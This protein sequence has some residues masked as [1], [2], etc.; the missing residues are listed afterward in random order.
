MIEAD[1]RALARGCQK[2]A[3]IVAKKLDILPGAVFQDEL[4]SAG[5]ANAGNR[6]RR[7]T[8][9]GS[10]GQPAEF[11]VQSILDFLI[12]FRS[13]LAIAPGFQRDEEESVV[14]GVSEAEQVEAD[15]VGG[16]L[17]ARRICENLLY[18]FSQ[19]RWCVPSTKRREVAC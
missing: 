15:N 4:K 18:L 7:E 14:G 12:L 19:P 6:R 16:V 10:D 3:Q 17:N 9:N 2:F 8:K 11:L 1:F 13:A 5:R